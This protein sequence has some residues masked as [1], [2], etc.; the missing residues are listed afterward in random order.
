M[1]KI[2]KSVRIYNP[3]GNCD[4]AIWLPFRENSQSKWEYGYFPEISRQTNEIGWSTC[5][6]SVGLDRHQDQ[7]WGENQHCLGTDSK[8]NYCPQPLVWFFAQLKKGR[9]FEL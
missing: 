5:D 2:C 7:P 4:I 1:T 9:Y 6:P 8:I 3:Q